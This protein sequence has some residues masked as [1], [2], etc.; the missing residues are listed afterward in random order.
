MTRMGYY[1]FFGLCRDRESLSRQGSSGVV[2]RRAFP[3]CDRA[4]EL[5]A[6]LIL[7]ACDKTMHTKGMR[8]QQECPASCHD[9]ILYVVI[10][11]GLGLGD[12]G[13]DRGSLS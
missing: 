5:G 12:Q 10:G 4:S 3:Y 11:L 9:R 6:R 13:R 7:P 1:L 8:A 2:S